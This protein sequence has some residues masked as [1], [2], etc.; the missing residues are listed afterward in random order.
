[1]TKLRPPSKMVLFKSLEAIANATNATGLRN[2][3]FS[4]TI[5]RRL[6]QLVSPVP[7]LLFFVSYARMDESLF[8]TMADAAIEFMIGI[9]PS[10]SCKGYCMYRNIGRKESEMGRRLTRARDLGCTLGLGSLNNA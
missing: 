5:H 7:I 9:F 2:L 6:L 8:P 4:L 1:M 10:V 3:E